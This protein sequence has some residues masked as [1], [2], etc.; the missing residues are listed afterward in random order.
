M[1]LQKSDLSDL[2]DRPITSV[3][4]LPPARAALARAIEALF[5]ALQRRDQAQQP[6]SGL[7]RV[8]AVAA[9]ATTE[10]LRAEIARLRAA[11]DADVSRWVEAGAKGPR[12]KPATELLD[13]E[14]RLGEIGLAGS[15]AEEQLSIAREGYLGAVERT[16]AAELER[17]RAVWSAAVETAESVVD[18]MRQA[19]AIVLRRE[20]LLRSLVS[21]LR[22]EGDRDPQNAN[23]ALAAAEKIEKAI[24]RVR[25]TPINAEP[26]AD[27]R[28]F[29][30]DLRCNP[31]AEL[32]PVASA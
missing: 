13:A 27:P 6:I 26:E 31:R 4:P 19:A 12:P 7:D 3:P 9:S 21:A 8:A 29:L 10:A 23:P 22:G 32:R 30:R 17:D 16:R 18:E 5:V 20:A 2:D 14:R 11:H 15:A 25:E 28:E 24:A 1:T